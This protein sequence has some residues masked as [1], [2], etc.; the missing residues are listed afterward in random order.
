[1]SDKAQGR[2]EPRI[3]VLFL[4]LCLLGMGNA[5]AAPVPLPANSVMY[6]PIAVRGEVN[7]KHGLAW[8][9]ISRDPNA[10][11]DYYVTWYYH[12]S[13][14]PVN[15]VAAEFVPMLWSDWPSLKAQLLRD[16]SREYCGYLLVANEP[17]FDTQANMTIEELIALIDWVAVQYPCAKIVAPQTHVCWYE[18]HPP[19]PPCPVL[20]ERFTVEKFIRTYQATHEGAN[21][22]V[23]AWGLHYGDVTV[24]PERLAGLMEQLTV[25][26][27][28]W[29]TEFNFCP[30]NPP[31]F[32]EWLRYLNQNPLVE[33]YAY[34]TNL[35]ETD[36]CVLAYF[37]SGE[38]NER[39]RVYAG[40][41]E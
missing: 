35:Q 2:Y 7:E 23:Y 8:S 29:Y 6:F 5:A 39:G 17:E 33:R 40:Y 30:D 9:W 4:W 24:W 28:F 22:P 21:P 36:Y 18:L 31:R 19:V 25:P 12:W 32:E 10:A 3:A 34:W 13:T 1:M 20:G 11:E 38:P 14:R 16:V 26:Q 15:G 37:A 27:R 41:G